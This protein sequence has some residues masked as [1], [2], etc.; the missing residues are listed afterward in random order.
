[1]AE[2]VKAAVRR[3]ARW[4][5]GGSRGL[6]FGLWIGVYQFKEVCRGGLR[7]GWDLSRDWQIVCWEMDFIP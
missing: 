4:L 1:M 2:S 7:S 5:E 6:A 3:F